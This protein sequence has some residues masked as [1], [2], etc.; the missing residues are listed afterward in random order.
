[1]NID[2]IVKQFK[3]CLW[4]LNQHLFGEKDERRPQTV[5][6]ECWELAFANE[7]SVIEN[8]FNIGFVQRTT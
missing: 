1:M 5:A 8:I 7:I 6:L 2:T 3:V 4:F